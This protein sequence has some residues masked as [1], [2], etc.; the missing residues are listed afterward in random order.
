MPNGV[1]N[2]LREMKNTN[3]ARAGGITI[4]LV[5][6]FAGNSTGPCN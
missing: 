4:G 2:R 5:K 6:G 3:D 1:Y